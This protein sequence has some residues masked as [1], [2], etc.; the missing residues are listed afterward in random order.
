[1]AQRPV[2]RLVQLS[3]RFG[4]PGWPGGFGCPDWPGGSAGLAAPVGQVGQAPGSAQ[5]SFRPGL[6]GPPPLRRQ[7]AARRSGPESS[8]NRFAIRYLS[9]IACGPCPPRLGPPLGPPLCPQARS[10]QA[11]SPQ[12]RSL[13]PGA[14]IRSRPGGRP[15]S[16]AAAPACG[17]EPTRCGD[18]AAGRPGVR[19]PD[20]GAAVPVRGLGDRRTARDRAPRRPRCGQPGP[21]R[22]GGHLH[23]PRVRDHGRGGAADR[24]GS[25][26]SRHPPGH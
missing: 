2:P 9:Q 4:C 18:T 6:P 14:P 1:M 11:R 20:R 8:C 15:A 5:A 17:P 3:G 22:P 19:G 21:H 13:R 7:S 23:L 16:P 24:R 10:P 12:A 26:G 25:P